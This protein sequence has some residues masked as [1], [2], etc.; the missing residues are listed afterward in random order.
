MRLVY[1]SL[2]ILVWA[3]A[4][5]CSSP[6]PT[7]TPLPTPTP[8][9]VV[10]ESDSTTF[11]KKGIV[12]DDYQFVCVEEGGYYVVL[13]LVN[14]NDQPFLLKL[15]QG[16]AE[17]QILYEINRKSLEEAEV[18]LFKVCFKPTCDARPGQVLIEV[19]APDPPAEVDWTV[20]V[21]KKADPA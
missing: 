1:V 11:A 5:G 3:V 12:H 2:L 17:A 18:N 13:T 14:E 15:Q 7:P 8:T 16:D 21:D 6:T 9:P 19:D 10:C 4:V 20:K